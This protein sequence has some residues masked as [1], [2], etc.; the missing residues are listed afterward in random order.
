M[1]WLLAL[2]SPD[3]LSQ[4]AA[5]GARAPGSSPLSFAL[6]AA[7]VATTEDEPSDEENAPPPPRGGRQQQAPP[8]E[9]DSVSR[10]PCAGPPYHCGA[11]LAVSHSS[12]GR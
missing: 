9:E 1:A 12:K 10:L 7:A 4:L 11:V 8:Q 3:R 5:R 6:I 2:T